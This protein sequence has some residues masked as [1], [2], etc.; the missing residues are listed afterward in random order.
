MGWNTP[1]GATPAS[2]A[3]YVVLGEETLGEADTFATI[4]IDPTGY[5]ELKITILALSLRA[6][7]SADDVGLQL[8]GESGASDYQYCV[9]NN[10][11]SAASDT[12]YTPTYAYVGSAPTDDGGFVARGLILAVIP[13]PAVAIRHPVQYRS[14]KLNTG[15]PYDAFIQFGTSWH[16]TEDPITTIQCISATGS[17]F[18]TGSMWKVEGLL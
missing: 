11:P 7:T 14:G 6:S 12:R 8:N 4:T 5:R 17:D 1:A 16:M 10:I 15:G 18:Q 2:S 13:L 3:P 9:G